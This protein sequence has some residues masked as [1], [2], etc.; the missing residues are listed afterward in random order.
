MGKNASFLRQYA[1]LVH[2][3]DILR[4]RPSGI[5]TDTQQA[6]ED[7]DHFGKCLAISLP[8]LYDYPS[9]TESL[10][11]LLD[12]ISMTGYLG[13]FLIEDSL[14]QCSSLNDTEQ[15]ILSELERISAASLNINP[16]L[17]QDL[18]AKAKSWRRI[19]TIDNLNHIKRFMDS[20]QRQVND[21]FETLS[22]E[23]KLGRA[24]AQSE[25]ERRRLIEQE[26]AR[27]RGISER[28]LDKEEK[29]RRAREE[30]IKN[31]RTRKN[32]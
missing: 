21:L 18:T 24:L 13:E 5:T 27:R 25:Q 6:I 23:E 8:R 15:Q 4:T 20:L 7:I 9:L 26:E 3:A 16:T 2:S 14:A 30:F 19:V 32:R 10:F 12:Q 11:A 28:E 22:T 1:D 31:S 17:L 29:R